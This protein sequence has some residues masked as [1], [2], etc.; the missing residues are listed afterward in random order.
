MQFGRLNR[1]ALIAL[2]IQEREKRKLYRLELDRAR[3]R[4]QALEA[5]LGEVLGQL[6]QKSLKEFAGITP[7]LRFTVLARDNFRCQYCG[8]SADDGARL[9]IDHVMPRSEG[10][11][12]VL[13]NLRT[14][15]QDCNSGKGKTLMALEQMA[16]RPLR[17]SLPG[18]QGRVETH[19]STGS[20]ALGSDA[21]GA[22]PRRACPDQGDEE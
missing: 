2:C 10:G 19:I 8:H 17:V 21:T 5:H 4:I 1:E 15:C 14:A 13:G 7:K 18:L 11:K 6:A 22:P 12:T 20:S 9:D 16:T 3:T